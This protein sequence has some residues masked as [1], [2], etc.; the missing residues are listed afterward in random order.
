MSDLLGPGESAIMRDILKQ[1]LFNDRMVCVPTPME[2]L[3]RREPDVSAA[4][5]ARM[6]QVQSS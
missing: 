3:S 2:K 4:R 6:R 5:A 1:K